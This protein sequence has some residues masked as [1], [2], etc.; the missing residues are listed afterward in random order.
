MLMLN[1]SNT[2]IVL[3]DQQEV[4][5]LFSLLRRFHFAVHHIA[6]D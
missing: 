2:S 3:K 6:Q 4:R 5:N 1:V